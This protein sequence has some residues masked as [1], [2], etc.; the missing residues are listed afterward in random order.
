MAGL[1][2]QQL[3]SEA[4]EAGSHP[5]LWGDPEQLEIAMWQVAL[6]H[7]RED[8]GGAGKDIPTRQMVDPSVREH[9]SN[10]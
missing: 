1:T 9:V 2:P 5:G 4:K 7:P 8:L 10:S 3:S 6:A